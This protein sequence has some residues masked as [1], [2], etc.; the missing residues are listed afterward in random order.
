MEWQV[1]NWLYFAWLS[2]DHIVEQHVHSMDKMLWVM[3]DEAPAR[4]IAT[5]GRAQRTEPQYGNVYDHFT[6][7][8]EWKNGVRC[9]AQ[10]RQWVNAE[11]DTS[12]WIFGTK[13]VAEL[14]NH[15][16]TGATPWSRKPSEVNMYDAEHVAMFKALR[17][18]TPINNGDYM[19]NATLMGIMARE[20]AYTGKAITWDE[21]SSSQLRLGPE[22]I[23]MKAKLD[24]PPVPVPGRQ[25]QA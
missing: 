4:V 5:G 16:I 9:I 8:F 20:S 25:G 14:M 21:I 23:D 6:S 12:D 3:K 18:G 10:C 15:K 19:C 7:T 24:V 1:R 22:V 13:G 17:A 11:S 2:G